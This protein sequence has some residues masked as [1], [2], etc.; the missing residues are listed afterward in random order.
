[1]IDIVDI[2]IMEFNI[3]RLEEILYFNILHFS[4]KLVTNRG[5]QLK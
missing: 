3:I 4:I 2:H 1:M 5:L